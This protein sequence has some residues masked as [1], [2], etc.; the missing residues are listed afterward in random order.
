MRR[1]RI[2]FAFVAAL[3]VLFNPAVFG[4]SPLNETVETTF[5]GITEI[6]KDNSSDLLEFTVLP[7]L[8]CFLVSRHL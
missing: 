3:M 5:S 6:F 8:F 2:I 4:Q 1:F 7:T